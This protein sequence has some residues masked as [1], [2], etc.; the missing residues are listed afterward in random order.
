MN[1]SNSEIQNK[2]Q[3]RT[4][5]AWRKLCEYI[6]ELAENGEDEFVPREFLGDEL[7]AQIHTLPETISKLKKVRKVGLYGSAL[8]RIPPEIGEMESLEYFD[9]YTSYDLHWLPYEL[10]KCKQLKDSRISTRALYGNYKNR[11]TFPSLDHNPVRYD[12]AVLRCSVCEKELTYETTNQMWISAYV[13]T[14]TIPM[15]A[16]LCSKR[17]EQDLL[18]P[19]K[20]YV[21]VPHKGGVDLIQPPDEDE[22]WK[23]EIKA[24]EKAEKENH[25]KEE[26]VNRSNKDPEKVKLNMSKLPMLKLVRK[27]WEK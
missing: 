22:L 23:L 7:F 15:L 11:M 17:C 25:H 13:G 9:P 24:L 3:D 8:K 19:P 6:E 18:T 21:Q 20:D 2:V 27:I 26:L 14:D 12:G 16:N 5:K 4:T 1:S 10:T